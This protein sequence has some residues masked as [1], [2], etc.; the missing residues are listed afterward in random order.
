MSEKES[1]DAAG[2]ALV[3]WVDTHRET[4]DGPILC[5]LMLD[6]AIDLCT[7]AL[8]TEA[9]MKAVDEIMREKI[10]ERGDEHEQN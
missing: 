2:L 7:F 3:E 4:V 5:T 9:T 10:R 8:G 6:Q 1:Y